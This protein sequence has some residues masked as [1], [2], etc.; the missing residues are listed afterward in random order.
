MLIAGLGNPTS[1]YEKTRHNAGFWFLDELAQGFGARFK[2]EAR[3]GGELARIER[4]GQDLWLLKPMTFM[5]RSGGPIRQVCQY[6]KIPLAEVLI[7]HDEL[8]LPPGDAKLK[9]AGGHG[10]HNGLRD[11]ISVFGTP[12]FL[13]L[14]LGIGHPG[15]KSQVVDY[16][17]GEPGR[18]ERGAINQAIANALPAVLSLSEGKDLQS[19]MTGLHS[20]HKK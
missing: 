14:R 18:D 16:V 13:R 6:F 15:E 20:A 9:K 4:P 10:G 19:V 2:S 5:N 3:F 12:D 11:I 8:D 1:R 7:V 17:L